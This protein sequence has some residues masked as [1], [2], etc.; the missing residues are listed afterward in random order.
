MRKSVF[1]EDSLKTLRTRYIVFP[2]F[3]EF[4]IHVSHTLGC[5]GNW[6]TKDKD[7]VNRRDVC[8]CDG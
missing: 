1:N 2:C 5:S 6:N 8:E 3:F 7:E 4:I